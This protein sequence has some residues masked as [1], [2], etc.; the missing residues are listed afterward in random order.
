MDSAK[1]FFCIKILKKLKSRA[2]ERKKLSSEM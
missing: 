2:I 1:K